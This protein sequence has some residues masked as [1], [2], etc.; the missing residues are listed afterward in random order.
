M[1]WVAG[2]A[3]AL[4][5]PVAANAKRLPDPVATHW[6][7]SGRADS[8]MSHGWAVAA[9][10]LIWLA[11]AALFG[12]LAWRNGRLRLAAGWLGAMLGLIG[13]LLAGL[14]LATVDANLDVDR[15]QDARLFGTLVTLAIIVALLGGGAGWFVGRALAGVDTA[16][17][18]TPGAPHATTAPLDI[19]VT[20]RAV[21]VSQASN[22]GM[23]ALGIVGLCAAASS[24]A[25][26]RVHHS[27]GPAGCGC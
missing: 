13:V 9:P 27:V 24:V 6:G 8:S 1:A 5:L 2:V 10:T 21:W 11:L 15:W 12:A 22:R 19:A 25:L 20:K 23:L 18:D 7:P 3:A 17:E 14:Q 4:T 26:S 16:D